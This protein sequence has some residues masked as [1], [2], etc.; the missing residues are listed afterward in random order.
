MDSVLTLPDSIQTKITPGSEAILSI[1]PM[2]MVMPTYHASMHRYLHPPADRDKII[3]LR[4]N[5]AR[6]TQ[7]PATDDQPF[8]YNEEPCEPGSGYVRI[9][10]YDSYQLLRDWAQDNESLI[11]K[12]IPARLIADDLVKTWSAGRLTDSA[13][14]APGIMRYDS[15]IGLENQLAQMHQNQTIYFR[16]L[17]FQADRFHEEKKWNDITNLHRAAAEYLNEEQ[18]PWFNPIKGQKS[19]NCPAC[20][21]SMALMAI[22]CGA[23]NTNIIKFAKEMHE[24]GVKIEDPVLAFYNIETKLDSKP[25]AK[26]EKEKD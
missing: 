7:Y 24:I 17:V 14:G 5:P 10:V 23:C 9:L 2:E 1:F 4:N 15:R 3:T 20:Q 19:K 8:F 13:Q 22:V 18:R 11:K 25:K 12:D 21:K 6:T 26:P 16:E